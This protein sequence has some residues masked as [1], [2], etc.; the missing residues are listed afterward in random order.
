MSAVV[1]FR[2]SVPE[3]VAH[4][5]DWTEEMA[6]HH[7]QALAFKER[8]GPT[9]TMRV[10][11]GQRFAYFEG[12]TV[13]DGW[14]MTHGR[15][16]PDKRYKA[17]KL[18]AAEVEA[19]N[20]L[21]PR[22][23]SERLPG[24]PGHAMVGNHWYT[25]GC[26]LY[27]GA[28]YVFWG[29]MPEG[30]DESICELLDEEFSC[31]VPAWPTVKGWVDPAYRARRAA[32]CRQTQRRHVLRVHGTK[33]FRNVTPEWRLARIRELRGRRLSYRAIGQVAEVWWGELLSE[34]RV[35]QLLE[36]NR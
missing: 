16:V 27:E 15:I 6:E 20:K 8:Y 35:R 36:E 24:M 22:D 30:V 13:P 11:R 3:V 32:M 4:C 31:G 7:Q 18:A 10:W 14:R 34:D 1:A 5:E 2:S 23:L 12:E 25:P 26:F 33:P 21:A 29:G 28:L 9:L 17:G 19:L